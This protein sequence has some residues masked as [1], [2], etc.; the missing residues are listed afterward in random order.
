MTELL[1]VEELATLLKV[2]KWQVYELAKARTRTGEVRDNP[3]PFVR[4]GRSMRFNEVEVA[5]WIET[6]KNTL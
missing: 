1:T 2:T 3:L 6:L 4:I 5:T